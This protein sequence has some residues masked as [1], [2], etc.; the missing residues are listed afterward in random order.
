MPVFRFILGMVLACYV[1]FSRLHHLRF[2]KREPM[3]VGILQVSELPPQC[4]F[5]RF[6]ASLHLAP[7]TWNCSPAS[8]GGYQVQLRHEAG[9]RISQQERLAFLADGFRGDPCQQNPWDRTVG[10]SDAGVRHERELE[11]VVS[12]LEIVLFDLRVRKRGLDH[13]T[14]NK[15]ESAGILCRLFLMVSPLWTASSIANPISRL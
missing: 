6:L 10:Q 8:S 3:L 9:Q 5:W 15:A 2:L 13:A 11:M 12:A 1:G 14:G 4:T 7:E